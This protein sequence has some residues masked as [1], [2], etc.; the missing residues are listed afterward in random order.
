[1]RGGLGREDKGGTPCRGRVVEMHTIKQDLL[2]I[3]PK[4]GYNVAVFTFFNHIDFL[5]YQ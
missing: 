5:L 3:A 2:E 4:V 1:M